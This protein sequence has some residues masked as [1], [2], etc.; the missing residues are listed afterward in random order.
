MYLLVSQIDLFDNYWLNPVDQLKA[1]TDTGWIEWAAK[2][3]NDL[4][5]LLICK[6]EMQIE[7]L[8]LQV[9]PSKMRSAYEDQEIHDLRD[10]L[11]VIS[12]RIK[13]LAHQ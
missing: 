6:K 3:W 2:K 10:S 11:K 5:W 4:G 8:D 12:H 7:L 9:I 13:L 1:S